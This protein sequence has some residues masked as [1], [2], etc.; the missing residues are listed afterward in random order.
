MINE[1]K[2]KPC[3]VLKKFYKLCGNLNFDYRENINSSELLNALIELKEIDFNKIKK[4]S[5]PIRLSVYSQNDKVIDRVNDND[6]NGKKILILKDGSH[7]LPLTDP[8]FSSKIILKFIEN[9]IQKKSY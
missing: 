8:D 7:V 6:E 9:D 1:F 2:N 4:T 3:S 5:Y